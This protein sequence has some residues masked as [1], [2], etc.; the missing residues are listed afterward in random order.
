MAFWRRVLQRLPTRLQ[1]PLDRA[2]QFGLCGCAVQLRA[3][4]RAPFH[5][6][7]CAAIP[8]SLLESELFGQAK[9]TFTGADRR[10]IGKFE[11][12]RG[13]PLATVANAT[14]ANGRVGSSI[15]VGDRRLRHRSAGRPRSMSWHR[16]C[17]GE[18]VLIAGALSVVRWIGAFA[19]ASGVLLIVLGVRLRS[20]R[21]AATDRHTHDIRPGAIPRHR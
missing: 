7:N 21:P 1:H 15:L 4:R 18:R 13:H 6:V 11:Q 17:S 3:L 14:D 10:G 19:I 20:F 5:A 16:P 9:G 2:E 8:Q 12:K